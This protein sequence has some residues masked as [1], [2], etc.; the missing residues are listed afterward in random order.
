M[1]EF[2]A[3]GETCILTLILTFRRK[4]PYIHSNRTF[5]NGTLIHDKQDGDAR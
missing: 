4:Q 1:Y 3:G 5:S 2:F